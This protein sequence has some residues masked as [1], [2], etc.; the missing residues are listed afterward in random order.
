MTKAASVGVKV[1][2]EFV[3]HCMQSYRHAVLSVHCCCWFR[4]LEKH[5][6]GKKSLQTFWSWVGW[7]ANHG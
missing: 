5:L 2:I 4:C 6:D 7:M 3:D 1:I